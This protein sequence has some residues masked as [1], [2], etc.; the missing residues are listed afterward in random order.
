MNNLVVKLID[1]GLMRNGS[2]IPYEGVVNTW[3]YA[4]PE[5]LRHLPISFPV[6]IWAL[7]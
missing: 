7:G 6:D 2:G 1:F 3:E 5:I 4:A